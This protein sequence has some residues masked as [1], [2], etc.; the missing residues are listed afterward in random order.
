[1]TKLGGLTIY[2][3]KFCEHFFVTSYPK[4]LIARQS[5]NITIKNTAKLTKT[6]IQIGNNMCSL[7]PVA[8]LENGRKALSKVSQLVNQSVFLLFIIFFKI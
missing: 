5:K 7:V 3:D 4:Y 8:V 6:I 1:M 2:W